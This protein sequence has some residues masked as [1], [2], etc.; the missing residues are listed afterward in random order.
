MA[1]T[2]TGCAW[3]LGEDPGLLG[4]DAVSL[5]LGVPDVSKGRYAFILIVK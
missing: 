2:L 5:A 1:L 4:F 3:L